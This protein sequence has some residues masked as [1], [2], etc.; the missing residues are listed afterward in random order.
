[1]FSAR[2]TGRPWKQWLLEQVGFESVFVLPGGWEEGD[3]WP[4]R[5]YRPAEIPDTA[6]GSRGAAARRLGAAETIKPGSSGP[7]ITPILL[8]HHA[9]HAFRQCIRTGKRKPMFVK[10]PGIEHELLDDFVFRGARMH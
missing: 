6:S 9:I 5:F 10:D 4:V 2:F 3:T 1:M 7:C 8:P